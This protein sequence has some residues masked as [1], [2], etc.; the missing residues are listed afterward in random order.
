MKIGIISDVHDNLRHLQK[1]IEFF[2]KEKISLLV[3]CGDW[4]A[5]FSLRAYLALKCPIRGVMGNGDPDIQ[6]YL[7]QLQNIEM[8]KDLDLSLSSR[9]LE[10]S[11]E[12]IRFGVFHG[13]D[14]NMN[15]CLTESQMFDVLCL[16]HTHKPLIGQK[17]KTLVVNPGS[18]IGYMAET[19]IQPA[20]VAL[21]DTA[22][23]KAEIIDL[24][25]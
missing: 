25:I 8:L 6:K 2:N 5:P 16:G 18:L 7:Y 15:A 19:G 10:F 22:T 24:K 3:H 11:I 21:Y 17:G 1:A 13:D 14:E 12:G 20:T 9:F 23:K 4:D